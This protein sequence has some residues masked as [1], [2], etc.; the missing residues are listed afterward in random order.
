MTLRICCCLLFLLAVRSG[1]VASEAPWREMTAILAQRQGDP[2]TV[3]AKLEE[4]VKRHPDFR[5]G[6]YNLGCLLM[7]G[8]P[9]R[10]AE[11]LL[12]STTTRDP[13]LAARAW[14]NLAHIRHRQGKVEEALSAA[15]EAVDLQPEN[16]A[17]VR[18]R[19]ELRRIHLI[20]RERL[21]LE[22]EAAAKRIR[23][24]TDELQPLRAGSDGSRL[25]Q[26]KG[27]AGGPYTFALLDDAELPPGLSLAADG[28][29]AGIPDPSSA[30]RHPVPIRITDRDGE[31]GED[32]ATIPILPP[33]AITTPTLGMAVR[34]E[35]HAV[36]LAGQGLHRPRWSATGL[37]PGLALTQGREGARITGRAEETGDFAVRILLEDTFGKTGRSYDLTVT[38]DFA[39]AESA[40]PPATVHRPYTARLTVRGPDDDYTWASAGIAGL[41]VEP[42]GSVGGEPVTAGDFLLPVVITAGNDRQV[43]A[44]VAVRINPLPVITEEDAWKLPAGKP[45]NRP[46]AHRGGTPPYAWSLADGDLPPGLELQ[47]GRIVGVP[48]RAGNT[49]VRIGL[50]DRWEAVTRHQLEIQVTPPEPDDEQEQGQ[51]QGQEQEGRQEGEQGEGEK[52]GRDRQDGDRQRGEDGDRQDADEKL[53]DDKGE[54]GEEESSDDQDAKEEGDQPADE[55]GEGGG[56]ED[57]AAERSQQRLL[58]RATALQWLQELEDDDKDALR[59]QMLDMMD[60]DEDGGQPW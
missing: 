37:P 25:L 4:L 30:G 35:P 48:Q 19:D 23:L 18:T 55:D 31:T 11:L 49:V 51:E 29:L 43:E 21:R 41:D 3:I 8:D 53:E 22:R 36:E 12:T 26:G 47:S 24:A 16:E 59:Y 17:F 27:G 2:G 45:V 7:A 56:E 15:E 28:T 6:A 39:P 32:R 5:A 58:R 9:G 40:L 10:A 20:H 33:L 52:T 13:E 1:L 46:L 57:D 34:G 60:D 54:R 50:A 44:E 38:A 14:H 42:T